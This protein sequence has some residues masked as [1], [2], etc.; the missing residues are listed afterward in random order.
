MRPNKKASGWINCLCVNVTLLLAF[1][2]INPANA[3]PPTTAASPHVPDVTK[4]RIQA[5]F[6]TAPL[7]FEANRG[8]TDGRV[9]F[10]A[11]GSG[12][13]LFLTS[14]EFV[15]ALRKPDDKQSAISRQLSA[16]SK[17]TDSKLETPNSKLETVVR[18]KLVGANSDTK[19]AGLEQL[20]GK[21][22]YF[23]GNDP[24]KWRTN[25][26][27]YKRLEYKDVYPGINLVFYG[28][29]RQLEYDFVVSPGADP[30]V[31]Q[32]AF[33]GADKIKVDTRGDLILQTALGDLRLHKPL[34][35]QE[36]AGV[37][38]EISGSYVDLGFRDEVSTL[39]TQHSKLKTRNHFVGFQVAAY[40]TNRPLIIDPV[41]PATPT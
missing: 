32:L 36:I 34:V 39:K 40:D 19:V 23:I 17:P 41:L 25:I 26:P 7:H 12:Y 5:T 27:T 16:Q 10:L 20:P 24:K 38:R 4:N 8:Q 9:K 37:R 11:R 2:L 15:L 14:T 18:M 29:Q 6:L 33:E 3:K 31:I 21:V 22:N 28:N 1:L 30:S 13:T 35:Y